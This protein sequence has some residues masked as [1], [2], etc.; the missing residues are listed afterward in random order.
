MF[1]RIL[2]QDAFREHWD[3]LYA[4]TTSSPTPLDLV[5][6]PL[7]VAIGL[8]FGVG[9]DS[10]SAPAKAMSEQLHQKAWASLHET[11]SS[12]ALPSV[13]ALILHASLPCLPQRYLCRLQQLTYEGGISHVCRQDQFGLVGLWHGHTAGAGYGAS[14]KLSS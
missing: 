6:L 12:K 4:G 2:D 7:V 8:L 10:A 1:Y 14:Q 3:Q 13:Q 11:L 5:V 9:A